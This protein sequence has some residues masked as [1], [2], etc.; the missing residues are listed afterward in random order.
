MMDK[1][2]FYIDG[3]WVEPQRPH[4]FNVIDP[5]TEE[6]CAA[7]SL[8]SKADVNLAVN[9]A[10]SA[11]ESQAMT[12]EMGAPTDFA[13]ADQAGCGPWHLKGFLRAFDEFEWEKPFAKGQTIIREP[14]GV[15][16]LITPWNWPVN[17][18][19]LK[20]IP[21]VLMGN[22][23]VLKPSEIAP[24]SAIVF[25]EFMHEA[26]FPK[27]VFNLVN[28]DGASVGEAMS[29]HPD[30]DM[31]SFTG[32]TRAGALVTKGAADTVKRVTLELGG[33]SPNI[34]FADC[35]LENAV[36][37]GVN[38][39]MENTGQ[40]C[41][42]PTRMIV[43]KSVYEDA[44][45]IAKVAAENVSV[46]NPRDKGNHIGPLVSQAQYDKVQAL[47][48]TG[49][50]EGA[51]LVT[52]GTGKPEGFNR[53]YFVRPTI[54][55]DVTPDM[56]LWREE[57][58]GPV[59]AITPFDGSE[60][61]AICMG[62]D[63]P[64]GLA[65]YLS[66]GDA[67]KG[68]RVGRGLRAGMVRVNGSGLGM[69]HPFGGYKQSGNGRE[70]GMWG[71]EDFTEKCKLLILTDRINTLTGHFKDHKKDNHSRRG[72]LKMVSS[73]R[74]LLDYLKRKDEARYTKLIAELGLRR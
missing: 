4:D 74:S 22:T 64:Y 26:G 50:K 29:S 55:A 72:L 3:A 30:I 46:G 52:G 73:R 9:A 36:T 6:A 69:G 20:V 65:A 37:N 31:I 13:N 60:N 48:E 68:G 71:L 12:M 23:C 1:K 32:S 67:A 47:I 63:T 51:R 57:V 16:G 42:A 10:R 14:I 7:I 5:A 8:G 35:D 43:E 11:F 34:I 41:N 54:F 18:I 2:L 24:L 17:Q 19:A 61:E 53:G 33:K 62:N 56:T 49:I 58:F 45:E 40:S 59:L 39:C 25:A 28:G 70:G 27:G 66:T 15:C 38:H 44:I 21:A